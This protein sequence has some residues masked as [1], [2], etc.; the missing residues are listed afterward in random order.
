PRMDS[1]LLARCRAVHQQVTGKDAHVTII[2]AGLECG[3]IGEPYPDM[4]M[5]SF[6]P[7]MHGVHSP[8]E[9]LSITSTGNVYRYLTA[10]LASL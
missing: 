4:E 2:H 10:L 7:T 6:G 1:K 8:A 3:I 9:R 5:I